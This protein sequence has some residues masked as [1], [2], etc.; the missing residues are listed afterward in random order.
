MLEHAAHSTLAHFHA[1]LLLQQSPH[2]RQRPQA[3]RQLVL[4]RVAQRNRVVN[5][6]EHFRL[7]LSRPPALL[8]V[9]QGMLASM[10]VASYPSE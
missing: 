7:S 5:P 3:K 2:N 4:P 9:L 6:M 10:P 1:M 8:A